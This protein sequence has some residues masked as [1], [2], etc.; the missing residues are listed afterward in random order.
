MAMR[1]VLHL[2]RAIV[3]MRVFNRFVLSLSILVF[4]LNSP[5]QRVA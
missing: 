3:K 4:R 2:F 5:C 1:N